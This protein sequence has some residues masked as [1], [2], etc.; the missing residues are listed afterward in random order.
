M[1]NT[2]MGDGTRSLALLR[3]VVVLLASQA[4]QARVLFHAME[5][6]VMRYLYVVSMARGGAAVSLSGLFVVLA[7]MVTLGLVRQARGSAPG[8]R[9]RA[10]C[11]ADGPFA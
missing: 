2:F 7:V 5:D 3:W 1:I 9:L 8:P 6:E 4:D 10:V 11:D